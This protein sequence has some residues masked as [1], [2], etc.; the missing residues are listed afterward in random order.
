MDLR[1]VSFPDLTLSVDT[2]SPV[3]GLALF[4]K[5]SGPLAEFRI[6]GGK[7]HSASLLENLDFLIR[8]AGITLNEIDF[9][10]VT[11]GPGSFTGLRVG[12]STVKGLCFGLEKPVVAVSSLKAMALSLQTAG[13][14]I[15]PVFD[16]RKREVYGAAYLLER[17][18]LEEVLPEQAITM[19][20]FIESILSSSFIQEKNLIFAGSGVSRYKELIIPRLGDRVVFAP[21]HL[22]HPLP[23]AAALLGF[24]KALEG[25]F[26]DP[27]SLQPVY[28]RKS[29]AEISEELRETG[30]G[31]GVEG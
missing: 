25:E 16:A 12:I 9:I 15:C 5:N 11:R 6:R 30:I 19:E 7:R 27:S 1:G 22:Q 13:G 26:V 18:R 10:T 21:E 4:R 31:T 29:E 14:L 17:G 28:L 3:G 23:S 2:V 8:S 20:G 24:E